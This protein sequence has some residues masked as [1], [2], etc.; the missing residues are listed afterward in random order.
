MVGVFIPWK[1]ASATHQGFCF[2][3]GELIYQR[4]TGLTDP[5]G[6]TEGWEAKEMGVG[7][8]WTS[9]EKNTGV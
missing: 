9:A 7:E 4:T 1:L 8:Q 3:F 6:L 5:G 2:S